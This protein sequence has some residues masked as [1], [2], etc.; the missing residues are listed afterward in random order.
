MGEYTTDWG[1]LFAGLTIAAAPITLL[2]IALSRQFIQGMTGGDGEP[3]LI[4]KGALV[5]S[6]QAGPTIRCTARSTCPPWR[7]PRRP[8]APRAS[9]PTARPM[10]GDP[11]RDPLP[12]IGIAKVGRS[13]PGLHHAGFEQ[14]AQVAAGADIIGIDATPRPR[15]GEPVERLIGRIRAEL[16]RRSLP[17]SPR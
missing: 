15:N 2:Y 1:M 11:R 6:C 13:L 8:A 17:I 10:C 3:M 9:A 4:P 7:R 5:V 16:G 14:A 12:I